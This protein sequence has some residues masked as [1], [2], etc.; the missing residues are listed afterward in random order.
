MMWLIPTFRRGHNLSFFGLRHGHNYIHGI[1]KLSLTNWIHGI[2]VMAVERVPKPLIKW[3]P[4]GVAIIICRMEAIEI[5]GLAMPINAIY[6]CTNLFCGWHFW[7]GLLV[8]ARLVVI[9]ISSN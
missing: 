8:R 7:N 2:Q 5:K 6:N 9:I 4:P 1:A 3:G